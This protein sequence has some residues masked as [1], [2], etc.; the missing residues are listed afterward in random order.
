[1]PGPEPSDD[2][3]TL[4]SLIQSCEGGFGTAK[5]INPQTEVGYTQ[6]RNRLDKLADE[7]LLNR[8]K[9]GGTKVYWLTDKAERQLRKEVL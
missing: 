9:V 1:M 2:D 6:T 4:L 5:E 7:G 8:R 3:I